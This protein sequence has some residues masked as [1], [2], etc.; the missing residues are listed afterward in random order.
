M[1]TRAD[2]LESPTQI[3]EQIVFHS[4]DAAILEDDRKT[5]NGRAVISSI[6]ELTWEQ[7]WHVSLADSYMGPQFD[8]LG[9]T[10]PVY[11]D[12]HEFTC[13]FY[14]PFEQHT[15]TY[16]DYKDLPESETDN[17]ND[18]PSFLRRNPDVIQLKVGS[19]LMMQ[20]GYEKMYEAEGVNAG[21]TKQR[22]ILQQVEMTLADAQAY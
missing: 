6:A 7:T 4:V 21:Q 17:A 16:P 12:L 1:Y 9:Y 19:K 20:I 2:L 10:E 18:N 13:S 8:H 15:R 22:L 5:Y 11:T 14:R 3:D